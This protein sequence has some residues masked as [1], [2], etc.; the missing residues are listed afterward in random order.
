MMNTVETLQRILSGTFASEDDRLQSVD[1]VK[2][3]F[4]FGI[5]NLLDW[6]G[7]LEDL[8]WNLAEVI[9][10]RNERLLL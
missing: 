3:E 9:N 1:I 5:S 10:E 8:R 6:M 7:F 4:H 2:N